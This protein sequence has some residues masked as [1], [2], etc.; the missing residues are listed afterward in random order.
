[1]KKPKWKLEWNDGMSVGIPEIDEDHKRFILLINELNRSI[2]ERMKA[3]EIKK[4]LQDV[5]EDANQHFEQ[6]EIF[7]RERQYPNAEGHAISH[8]IVKNTLKRIQDSFMPYGLDAE[9]VDAA[10]VIKQILVNH[11]LTE[12]MQYADFFAKIKAKRQ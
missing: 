1:M 9:W 11:I 12:D 6:E 10:L 3:T 7:F 2:T 5:I 8:N 4:R